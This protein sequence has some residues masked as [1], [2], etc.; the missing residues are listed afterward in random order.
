MPDL[1][2]P[3]DAT[4]EPPELLVRCLR[5]EAIIP[6]TCSTLM[7][8]E[9]AERVGGFEES[10][11]RLFTDQAFYTKMLLAA[12]VY[13]AGRCWDKYRMHPASACSVAERTGFMREARTDYLNWVAVY[14]RQQG[15]ARG[16]LLRTLR[17]QR[18]VHRHPWA[19]DLALGRRGLRRL[20]KR[21]R[22]GDR[23]RAWW[24]SVLA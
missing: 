18:W 7:R 24:R 15:K 4:L 2:V 23:L 20:R 5:R 19:A 22:V 16:R 21:Y 8:R 14:L 9:L 17:I 12:P 13:V 10:F 6:G 1:G 11:R 3:L